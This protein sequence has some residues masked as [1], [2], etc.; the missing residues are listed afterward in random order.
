MAGEEL[1]STAEM[2]RLIAIAVT[3]LGI[4]EVRFTGGEPLLRRDLAA[5]IKGTSALTPRPDISMTTNGVGLAHRAA[6]LASAGLDRINVSLDSSDRAA[7]AAITR[8]DYLPKVMDGLRAAAQAGIAPIKINAVLMRGVN[9]HHACDLLRLCMELDY[10]LR[11]IEQMPLDSDDAWSATDMVTASETLAILRAAFTLNPDAGTRG[12]AP[13]ELWTVDDTHHRVGIIASVTQPFCGDCDRVRLTADGAIRS[14][15]FAAEE[16]DLRALLRANPSGERG[17][18]LIADR[19][20]DAL[21]RKQPGHGINDT[22]FL[23]PTRPMSAI[24]G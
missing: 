2:N 14:C 20:R 4:R 9:E 15:L 18:T 19:W 11:F 5:I 16:T 13:A 6:A 12:S 22:G 10:E 24:G 21:W 1:L 8:R 3:H 17:D 23:H 7:Y